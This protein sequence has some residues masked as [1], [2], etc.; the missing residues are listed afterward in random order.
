MTGAVVAAPRGPARGPIPFNPRIVAAKSAR[1]PGLSGLG[2]LL[3]ALGDGI[4]DQAVLRP[5]RVV[6]GVLHCDHRI[7]AHSSKSSL[8][9]RVQ[10]SE[11]ASVRTLSRSF[12]LRF[13]S[14]I[15]S[16][17][18]PNARSRSC[19]SPMSESSDGLTP[20]RCLTSTSTS[21]FQLPGWLVLRPQ[22]RP[23][24]QPRLRRDSERDS[25][26]PSSLVLVGKWDACRYAV[27]PLR[28][29]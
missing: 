28:R 13:S 18:R 17:S 7:G 16:T 19:S 14:R 5:V 27:P 10:R 21:L 8:S 23:Q 2:D 6:S 3:H 24:T 4:D 29:R 20:S 9:R 22:L 25:R 26:F 1:K 12:G 11:T 15:R